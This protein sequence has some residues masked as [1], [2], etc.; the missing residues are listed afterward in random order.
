MLVLWPASITWEQ[1]H[2]HAARGRP[3]MTQERDNTFLSPDVESNSRV[4]SI[5][6]APHRHHRTA[7]PA[8]HHHHLFVT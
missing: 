3:L 5:L 7:A 4:I 8:P 6:T 1:L 2:L